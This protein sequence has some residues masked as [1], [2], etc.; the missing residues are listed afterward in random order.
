MIKDFIPVARIA[1]GSG[2]DSKIFSF[3]PRPFDFL[4]CHAPIK[5]LF[6]MGVEIVENSELDM[7]DLYQMAKGNPRVKAIAQ[8][9]A[10]ELGK[11]NTYPDL[12]EPMAQFEVLVLDYMEKNLGASEYAVFCKQMLA[13]LREVLW[14]HPVLHQ[15][16]SCRH[17]EF[18]SRA[19]PI[20]MVR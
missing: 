4:T 1:L 18:P 13:V 19:N 10:K 3:G 2:R 11:G 12:M 8:D 7:F 15:F 6:E 20:S 9:M 17:A 16:T 14:L 5:P